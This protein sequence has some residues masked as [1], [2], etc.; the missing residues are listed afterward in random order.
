M[1]AG[2]LVL[3][4]RDPVLDTRPHTETW[5]SFCLLSVDGSALQRQSPISAAGTLWLAKPEIFTTRPLPGKVCWPLP[6]SMVAEP[7]I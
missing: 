4:Q 3:A 6:Y 1:T 5:H 2:T 7:L